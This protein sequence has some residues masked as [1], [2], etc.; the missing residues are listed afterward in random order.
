MNICSDKSTE[1][2]NALTVTLLWLS[3]E[4]YKMIICEAF[5]SHMNELFQ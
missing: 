3:I 5:I 1:I 4:E 2:Q